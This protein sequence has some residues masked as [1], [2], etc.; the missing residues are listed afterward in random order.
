MVAAPCGSW[1]VF[2]LSEVDL[3]GHSACSAHSLLAVDRT[4]G[5]SLFRFSGFGRSTMM[6]VPG[7]LRL[8]DAL[9]GDDVSEAWIV[10]S[11]AAEAALADAIFHVPRRG[12][13][14]ERGVARFRVVRLGGQM[15]KASTVADPFDGGDVFMYR[16]SSFAALLE[17]SA[18]GCDGCCG[19]HD[20]G[21]SFA[22]RVVGAHGAVGV[23]S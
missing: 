2:R 13:V 9:R 20:S 10:W 18:Q 5:L 21:G 17:A 7:A 16:D 19:W 8:D 1:A 22:V 11:A 12:L 23:Y 4:R 6:F 3:S 15:H 14:L